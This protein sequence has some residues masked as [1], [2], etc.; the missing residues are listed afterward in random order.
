MPPK[1]PCTIEPRAFSVIGLRALK[2][3]CS[4]EPR[5]FSSIGPRAFSKSQRARQILKI[6]RFQDFRDF[7]IFK[8]SWFQDFR[9]SRL[10]RILE[11]VFRHWGFQESEEFNNMKTSGIWRFQEFQGFENSWFQDSLKAREICWTPP[12]NALLY[13]AKSNYLY[14]ASTN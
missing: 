1:M 5:A 3:P 2:M 9:I 8:I 4:I 7:R 14:R 13:R 6:C 11:D 10:S 12:K